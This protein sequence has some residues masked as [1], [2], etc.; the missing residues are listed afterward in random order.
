[1]VGMTNFW[2]G[3]TKDHNLFSFLKSHQAVQTRQYL[4]LVTIYTVEFER[5]VAADF[6]TLHDQICTT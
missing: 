4:V 5:F 3:P 1:M 6:R 2:R